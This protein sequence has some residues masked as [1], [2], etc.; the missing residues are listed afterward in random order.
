[1]VFR[2]GV[3]LVYFKETNENENK[4]T[5]GAQSKE[6]KIE[7]LT[8]SL[9]LLILLGFTFTTTSILCNEKYLH[10]IYH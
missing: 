9:L 7:F 4:A 10:L 1:M 8:F 6:N 3:A 2:T 5:T